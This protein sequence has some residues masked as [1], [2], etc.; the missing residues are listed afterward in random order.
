MDDTSWLQEFIT[1][2]VYRLQSAIKLRNIIFYLIHFIA[3]FMTVELL[4]KSDNFT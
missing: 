1:V 3:Y 4:I 2:Q